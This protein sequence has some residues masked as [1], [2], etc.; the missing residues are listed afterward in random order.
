MERRRGSRARDRPAAAEGECGTPGRRRADFGRLR[1][2]DHPAFRL[3]SG[4]APTSDRSAGR[5]TRRAPTD[6]TAGNTTSPAASARG[7]P[8]SARVLGPRRRPRPRTAGRP[9]RRP[10]ACRCGG[11][12][13]AGRPSTGR[14]AGPPTGTRSTAQARVAPEQHPRL[15]RFP[16]KRRPR[17]P[18]RH[19]TQRKRH[20]PS[21]RSIDRRVGRVERTEAASA[22][23]R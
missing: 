1:R 9:P 16:G 11:A 2:I 8:D 14:P 20:A 15:R 5:N 23:Q 19:L 6:R 17:A 22:D 10:P 21:V 12:S 4:L 7:T 3:G 13:A 18:V